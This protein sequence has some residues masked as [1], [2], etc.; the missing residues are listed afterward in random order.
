MRAAGESGSRVAALQGVPRE[1]RA[2]RIF[3]SSFQNPLSI[4]RRDCEEAAAFPTTPTSCWRRSACACEGCG[5][6]GCWPEIRPKILWRNTVAVDWTVSRGAVAGSDGWLAGNL[7]FTISGGSMEVIWKTNNA[8]VLGTRSS[9]GSQWVRLGQSPWRLGIRNVIYVGSGEADMRSSISHGNGMYKST[10]AGKTW[11]HIGLEDS[12]QIA[13]IVVDPDD[14]EKVFVAALGHAYGPNKERGVFRSNDGGKSWQQ[15]LFKDENTGA[16]DLAMEPENSKKHIRSIAAER[17]RPPWSIYPPSKGPGSGL[18][19]SKDGG[20][21]WELLTGHGLPTEELGRMGNCVCSE[22]SKAG[23][24]D[25]GCE[26]GWAV[27]APTIAGRIG[28]AS[29]RMRG[30]GDADGISAR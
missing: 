11:T 24:S 22:Q 1:R 2:A 28:R 25:R 4:W 23:L 30:F 7:R 5:F 6:A 3:H 19:R 8:G 16:I 18:Y 10:D 27:S 26:G 21:H 29:R 15:V 20:E 12:R 14:S 9:T 13:R 17:E